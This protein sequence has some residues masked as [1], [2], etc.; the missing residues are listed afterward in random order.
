[1]DESWMEDLYHEIFRSRL[2]Y[3][4]KRRLSDSSFSRSDM[5][6]ILSDE[7]QK[8]DLAWAGKSPVQEITDSATIAAYEHFL[9]QWK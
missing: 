3:L 9:A 8:Q 1:M 6:K 5:E 4:G 7:Y 2:E